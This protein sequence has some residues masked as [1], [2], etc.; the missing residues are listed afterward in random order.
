MRRSQV[1]RGIEYVDFFPISAYRGPLPSRDL[2]G[3]GGGGGGGGFAFHRTAAR[4]APGSGRWEEA[5]CAQALYNEYFHRSK[6]D[7]ETRNSDRDVSSK[8]DSELEQ[9]SV[10][11]HGRSGNQGSA[12]A[13]TTRPAP[14]TEDFPED[15]AREKPLCGQGCSYANNDHCQ[16]RHEP[17]TPSGDNADRGSK[18]GISGRKDNGGDRSPSPSAPG[19]DIDAPTTPVVSEKTP[20]V[21]PVKTTTAPP[22]R[23][24]AG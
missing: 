11:L 4:S 1:S 13:S 24:P 19:D 2:V 10:R 17:L 16:K 15:P 5:P 7:G 6:G 9:S 12:R 20:S 3:G 21:D 8:A 22:S 14:R 23:D 18:W